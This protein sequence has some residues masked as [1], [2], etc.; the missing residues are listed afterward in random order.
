[1][2]RLI[3]LFFF[4]ISPH[5]IISTQLPATPLPHQGTPQIMYVMMSPP[6]STGQSPINIHVDAK[7]SQHGTQTTTATNN[8]HVTQWCTNALSTLQ[9]S[10]LLNKN[11]WHE[12]RFHLAI[13]IILG[14][15]G[16]L[17]RQCQKINILLK[18]PTA[19]SSW[20]PMYTN[21]QLM[22]QPPEILQQELLHDIQGIYLQIS[23]PTNFIIPLTQFIIMLDNE[24][25]QLNSFLSFVHIIA[26]WNF[27]SLLPIDN[28]IS[29][30][31]QERIDRLTFIRHLFTTW[32]IQYK[33]DHSNKR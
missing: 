31:I 10:S 2:K 33:I 26:P 29:H 28:T 15:Y 14:T 6:Q 9:S 20:K 1:M 13:M 27:Y 21:T 18:S 3:I 4:T 7:N 12:K 22:I 24:L 8:N 11:W 23:E 17:Y 30:V 16:W 19:W 25:Q 32:A 5:K